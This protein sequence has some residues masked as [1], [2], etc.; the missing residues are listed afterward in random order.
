MLYSSCSDEYTKLNT[1]LL[2]AGPNQIQSILN[3]YEPVVQ[4]ALK[5]Q[6]QAISALK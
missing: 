4:R 5:E 6:N 1:Q 3:S 2:S